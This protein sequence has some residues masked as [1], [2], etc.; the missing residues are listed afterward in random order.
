MEEGGG[1]QRLAVGARSDVRGEASWTVWGEVRCGAAGAPFY[2]GQREAE[3]STC[4][5]WPAR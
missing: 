1:G 3:A 4:L 2:R 5:Q